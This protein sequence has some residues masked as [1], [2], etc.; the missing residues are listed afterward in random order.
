MFK[1]YS[2]S[3]L[4]YRPVKLTSEVRRALCALRIVDSV[5]KMQ[6]EAAIDAA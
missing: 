1:V 2:S 5:C 3:A 4:E 6:H